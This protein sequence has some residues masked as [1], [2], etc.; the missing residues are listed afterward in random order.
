MSRIDCLSADP[1]AQMGV[2]ACSTERIGLSTGVTSPLTR[3]LA[4]TANAAADL[5][6]REMLPGLQA[7]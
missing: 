1:Y 2:W 6:A 3:T 5:S 4:V 7:G